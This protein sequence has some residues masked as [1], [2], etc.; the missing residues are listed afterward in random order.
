MTGGSPPEIPGGADAS[1]RERLAA[2]A[3]VASLIGH[4]ARNRLATLRAALELLEAGLEANFPPEYR[5][6]LLRELDLFIG[7][8]NVGLDMLRCDS[9]AVST[10]SVRELVGEAVGA[11]QPMTARLGLEIVPAYGHERDQIRTDRRLL[12]VVLLNLLRNAA[13][14]L[15]GTVAPRIEVRITDAPGW[16]HLEVEDNGPGVPPAKREQVLLRL[17]RDGQAGAGFGLSICRDALLLLG[18]SIRH[19]T[20]PGKPG[21][22][23][24]VSVPSGN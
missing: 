15:P 3:Y 10:H 23:F 24:R 6:S 9:A 4:E 18:G 8:F 13:E 17:D 19:V 22:C 2:V 16:L 20:P 11:M 14:A 7:D 5:S 12:R 1:A 21:A